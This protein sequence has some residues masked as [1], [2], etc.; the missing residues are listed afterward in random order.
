MDKGHPLTSPEQMA[1]FLEMWW[2]SPNL[3]LIAVL[4][5]W[6][7]QA[8]KSQAPIKDALNKLMVLY[9]VGP[10]T[11]Y[12]DLNERLLAVSVACLEGK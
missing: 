6:Q 4:R 7:Q 11:Q 1:N 8:L 3:N 9:P 2:G 5:D 12:D 10:N